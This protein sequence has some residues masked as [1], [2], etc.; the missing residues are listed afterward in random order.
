MRT[1]CGRAERVE[2]ENGRETSR[3][4]DLGIGIAAT[5]TGN[6]DGRGLAWLGKF[7]EK[8]WVAE[9]LHRENARWGEEETG[10]V[11]QRNGWENETTRRPSR[12]ITTFTSVLINPARLIED[13][14]SAPHP[15]IE[16][17]TL[18]V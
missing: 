14:Q 16:G 12:R 5:L 10:R 18:P 3:S 17:P 6:A 15:G 1:G 8:G 11:A 7:R 13:A 2:A 9:W 4:G